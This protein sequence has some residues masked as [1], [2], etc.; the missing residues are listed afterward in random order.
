MGLGKSIQVLAWN[1]H[2]DGF[3]LLIVTKATLKFN[4]AEEVEKAYPWAKVVICDSQTT[5]EGKVDV[6]S[7]VYDLLTQATDK[8]KGTTGWQTTA[9]A[10]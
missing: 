8:K 7:S 9:K 6:L 3:P 1:W 10:G 5:F 4:I 2:I